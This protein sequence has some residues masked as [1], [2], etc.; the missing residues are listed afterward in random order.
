MDAFGFQQLLAENQRLREQNARFE[1]II[2]DQ[3]KR[4]DE[5]ERTAK[6][7]AAPFSKGPPKEKPKKPGRGELR[8]VSLGKALASEPACRVTLP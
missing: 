8:T 6:R 1:Q 2:R 3:Q 5:L 4:I 7:Q